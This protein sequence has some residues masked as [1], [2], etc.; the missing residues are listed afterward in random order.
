MNTIV[1]HCPKCGAPI[2]VPAVWGGNSITKP[3]ITF[4]CNCNPA[5]CDQSS[6]V[7]PL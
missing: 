3:P 6:I 7:K 1:G 4:S 5:M 2:Y